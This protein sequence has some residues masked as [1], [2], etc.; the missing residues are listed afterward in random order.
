VPFESEII[1]VDDGSDRLDARDVC[2]KYVSVLP[3]PG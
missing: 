1:V 2:D 3:T